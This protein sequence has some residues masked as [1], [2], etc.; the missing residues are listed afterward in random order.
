[1]N[2]HPGFVSLSDSFWDSRHKLSLNS[3]DIMDTTPDLT[4]VA[5]KRLLL[6]YGPAV[7]LLKTA[8]LDR[9]YLGK[10]AYNPFA[11]LRVGKEAMEA[12]VCI[13]FLSHNKPPNPLYRYELK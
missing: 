2:N 12:C 5:Y 8:G 10:T 3:A 9:A 7:G 6:Q 11:L 4:D 13:P 1:M